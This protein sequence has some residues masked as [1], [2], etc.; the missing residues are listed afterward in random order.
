[1]QL[2]VRSYEKIWYYP[3]IFD[4]SLTRL[5]LHKYYDDLFHKSHEEILAAVPRFDEYKV[6]EMNNGRRLIT[7]P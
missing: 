3:Q 6:L 4:E 5:L 2:V 7:G 1:M